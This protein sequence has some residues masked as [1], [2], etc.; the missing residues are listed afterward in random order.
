MVLLF[1][2]LKRCAGSVS[3]VMGTVYIHKRQ[4][5]KERFT[6]NTTTVLLHIVVHSRQPHLQDGHSTNG[7]TQSSTSNNTPVDSRELNS[8]VR[9]DTSGGAKNS[10]N[11]TGSSGDDRASRADGTANTA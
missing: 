9:E 10:T 4:S 6:D 3:P 7:Q 5:I 8:R 1:Q 2:V 11:T